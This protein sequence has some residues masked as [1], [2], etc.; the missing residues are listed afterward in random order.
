[1]DNW[2]M[3]SYLDI[4]FAPPPPPHLIHIVVKSTKCK[5]A[6]VPFGKCE[7]VSLRSRDSSLG[8][9]KLMSGLGSRCALFDTL[10]LSLSFNIYS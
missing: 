7:H 1:M 9:N 5:G 10:S 6:F 8:M 2:S 3:F 4:R